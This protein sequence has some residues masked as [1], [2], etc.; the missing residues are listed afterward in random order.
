MLI[1][2]VNDFISLVIVSSRTENVKSARSEAPIAVFMK[3]NLFPEDGGSRFLSN[4]GT[5]LPSYATSLSTR[6]E[7]SNGI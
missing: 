5:C 2:Y 6:R 4:I 3:S 1:F 7:D